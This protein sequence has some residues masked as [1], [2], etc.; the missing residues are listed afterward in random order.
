MAKAR[1]DDDR[2]RG[3]RR[4]CSARRGRGHINKT[5]RRDDVREHREG[6]PAAVE[7]GRSD[8][9]EGAAAGAEGAGS[10]PGDA[11]SS[12][13]AAAS[14]SRTRRSAAA[15]R[16]TSA[17]S[18]GTCRRSRCAIRRTFQACP[19]HNWANAIA[20]ATPIA[21]KGV[22]AGAKVQAM[23]VLDLLMRPELVH[24]GVGLLQQRP[25]EGPEVHRRSFGPRT[26]RR[27]G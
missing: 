7:R 18:R 16:T 3:A 11:S 27:S 23:T 15:A 10:R 20:M 19:G 14:R 8:A 1:R 26:S 24:A 21:H 25:D 2:H 13:C 6:R 4:A 12:R 5:D 9:G 17:T 22:D